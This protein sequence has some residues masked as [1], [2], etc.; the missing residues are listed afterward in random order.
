MAS[1]LPADM[2]AMLVFT[3]IVVATASL[4]QTFLVWRSRLRPVRV[5]RPLSS[6][7]KDDRGSVRK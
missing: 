3:I 4:L 6:W 1:T 2:L 7:R 5:A